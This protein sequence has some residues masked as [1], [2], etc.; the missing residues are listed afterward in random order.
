VTE[1]NGDSI[2]VIDDE[3]AFADTLAKRLAMRG[4][5][6]LTAYDGRSGLELVEQHRLQGVVLDLRLPDL[7]GAQVLRR[8]LARRPDLRVVILTAHG[9]A[10]DE[11]ECLGVGA[12][13]FLHKPVTLTDLIQALVTT[14]VRAS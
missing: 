9:T 10:E 8:I 4:L 11:Q 1:N 12:V 5:R 14:S 7:E 13:A 6:C 3:Q 2:L